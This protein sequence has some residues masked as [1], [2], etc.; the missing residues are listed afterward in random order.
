MIV[1]PAYGKPVLSSDIALIQL[2]RP[3]TMSSRV[4]TVCLPD[5]DD[6]L[7]LKSECYIT[8]KNISFTYDLRYTVILGKCIFR[9]GTRAQV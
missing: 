7:A 3:A 4:S 9:A 6:D 1:H 8:G 5:Q 2:E